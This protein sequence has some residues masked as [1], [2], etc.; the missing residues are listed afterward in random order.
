[1]KG[2]VGEGRRTKVLSYSTSR[3]PSGVEKG[4]RRREGC[5]G[6][7]RRGRGGRGA[8]DEDASASTT[9][10]SPGGWQASPFEAAPSLYSTTSKGQVE[11][12]T[13]RVEVVGDEL[14]VGEDEL[15]VVGDELVVGGNEL[16]RGESENGVPKSLRT[17]TEDELVGDENGGGGGRR[18]EARKEKGAAAARGGSKGPCGC[19]RKGPRAKGGARAEENDLG[20][21]Q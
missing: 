8:T 12:L 1:M 5:K 21:G 15:E 19:E 9:F 2:E 17:R 6:G 16:G 4:P 18:G 13:W 14:E 7:R 10:E 20:G 11:P 3:R